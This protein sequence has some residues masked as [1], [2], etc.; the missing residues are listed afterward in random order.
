M[1]FGPLPPAADPAHAT[2]A[3]VTAIK[4]KIKLY[5]VVFETH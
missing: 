2:P 4:E 3:E 5:Q 1:K